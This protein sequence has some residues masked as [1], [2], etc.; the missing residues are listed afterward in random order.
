MTAKERM[1]KNLLKF[2]SVFL[3]HIVHNDAAYYICTEF[4]E[5]LLALAGPAAELRELVGEHVGKHALNLCGKQRQ[6][7]KSKIWMQWVDAVPEI[8]LC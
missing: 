5:R 1:N 2:I 8:S 6:Q 7:G 3:Q 4:N